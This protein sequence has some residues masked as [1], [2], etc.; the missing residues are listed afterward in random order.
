MENNDTIDYFRLLCEQALAA[1][2]INLAE[3]AILAEGYNK[4]L[5]L[6]A[7]PGNI[8]KEEICACIMSTLD[9]FINYKNDLHVG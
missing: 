2:N 1:N 4:L 3:N 6:L 5:E 7:K 9:E 8:T